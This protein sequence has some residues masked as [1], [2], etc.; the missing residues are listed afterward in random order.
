[1]ILN[2]KLFGIMIIALLIRSF[3]L[4]LMLIG[5]EVLWPMF[6]Q[7]F[8]K[9]EY[10]SWMTQPPGYH[11]SIY[12][13]NALDGNFYSHPRVHP[14][15][16]G[17]LTIVAI[18]YLA[19]LLYD[20]KTA[21]LSAGIASV[22]FYHILA[23]LQLD[24][25]GNM[26][27]LLIT[28]AIYSYSSFIIGSNKK[29]LISAGFLFGSSL[30]VKYTAIF[31]IPIL[32]LFD[33][34]YSRLKNIKWIILFSAVGFIVFSLFPIVTILISKPEIFLITVKWGAENLFTAERV[35]F[36]LVK[37]LLRHIY[38]LVVY[39]TPLLFL[40]SLK[41]LPK[42]REDYLFISWF[43]V[44]LFLFIFLIPGGDIPKSQM[45]LIPPMCI[46]AAREI[47]R[48]EIS[49]SDL[50]VGFFSTA[51][52]LITIFSL[53]SF[54]DTEKP[55]SFEYFD[56]NVLLK[57]PAIW[58]TSFAGPLF[59][60]SFF[61]FF[62]VAFLSI[63]FLLLYIS[64]TRH[65]KNAMVLFIAINLAF[66]ILLTEEFLFYNFSPDYSK[67]I[68]EM[69]EY[70]EKNQFH[71]PLYAFHSFPYYLNKFEYYSLLDK[72][73]RKTLGKEGGVVMWLNI[74]P[75]YEGTPIKNIFKEV[76]ANCNLEKTFYD[77][78]TDVGYIFTC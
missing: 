13:Y 65:K 63:V 27:L 78:N 42:R 19:E 50:K 46:L 28:L 11:L 23:S 38:S 10:S 39:A 55:L 61:S 59:K 14:L 54:S 25:D 74:P 32:I 5:D 47:A 26:L 41:V 44:F 31:I 58:L 49:K 30:W 40:F 69:I 22:S 21:L 48:L 18:Y 71:G 60:V 33:L 6:Y 8:I 57:N 45:L 20:E 16:Y 62:F 17:V 70:Y 1:M 56:I 75:V 52:F 72:D 67:V 12:L 64:N 37:S 24:K 43:W 2:K 36:S 7:N 3:G 76:E 51:V 34:F 4:D 73:V 9:G 66:N 15:I 35:S 68:S 77:K 53:N 29:W